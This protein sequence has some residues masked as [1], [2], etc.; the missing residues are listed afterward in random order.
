M[1]M[2]WSSWQTRL[3][4][5]I[6]TLYVKWSCI[7]SQE[8]SFLCILKLQS[9][10]WL[11]GKCGSAL[12][13]YSQMFREWWNLLIMG[14]VRMEADC[15]MVYNSG[16][17]LARTREWENKISGSCGW[18]VRFMTLSLIWIMTS[19]VPKNPIGETRSYVFYIFGISFMVMS[20]YLCPTPPAANLFYDPSARKMLRLDKTPEWQPCCSRNFEIKIRLG[21]VI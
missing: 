9:F 5:L 10:S 16:F 15:H 1:G 7:V 21:C 6:P 4:F 12:H 17:A 19:H 13:V 14:I 3:Y 20:Y 8:N 18:N 11:Y 2:M